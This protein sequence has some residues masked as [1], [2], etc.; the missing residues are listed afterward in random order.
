MINGSNFKNTPAACSYCSAGRFKSLTSSTW[1]YV[2]SKASKTKGTSIPTNE[3]QIK[4]YWV[5]IFRWWHERSKGHSYHSSDLFWKYSQ[6]PPFYLPQCFRP[7]CS[8]NEWS[9]LECSLVSE[10]MYQRAFFL[11]LISPKQGEHCAC[12]TVVIAVSITRKKPF[13]TNVLLCSFSIAK[14]DF[15]Y[16]VKQW[17]GFAKMYFSRTVSMYQGTEMA[18][19]NALLLDLL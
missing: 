11:P 19:K 7:T 3:S 1:G 14:G 17:Q 12:V 18:F 8:W 4:S 15:F 16:A 5:L 6:N 10:A 2:Y 13:L 9:S